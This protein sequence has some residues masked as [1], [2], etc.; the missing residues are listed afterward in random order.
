MGSI[1]LTGLEKFSDFSAEGGSTISVV[2]KIIPDLS[3]W[4]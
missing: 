1:K 3:V 4:Y 2:F